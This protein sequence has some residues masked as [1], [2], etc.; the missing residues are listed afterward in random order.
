MA[1]RGHFVGGRPGDHHA[2]LAAT[3]TAASTSAAV[4]LH[5]E[6]NKIQKWKNLR[7]VNLNSD[8]WSA[9]LKSV[10]ITKKNQ[11]FFLFLCSISQGC[12]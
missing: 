8:P 5:C 10:E 6:Q 2:A 12:I 7:L 11:V 4:T 9:F 3:A 1:S